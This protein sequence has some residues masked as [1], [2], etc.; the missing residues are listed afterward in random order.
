MIEWLA[1]LLPEPSLYDSYILLASPVDASWCFLCLALGGMA[2]A[3]FL[4]Q[5]E[6]ENA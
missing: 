2:G 4:R 5:P 3:L 6:K 1:W